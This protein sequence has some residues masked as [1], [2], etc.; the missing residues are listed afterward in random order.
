MKQFFIVNIRSVAV[1]LVVVVACGAIWYAAANAEPALGTYAVAEGNVAGALDEPGAVAAENHAGIAFQE[2]GQIAHVYVKEGDVVATGAPLADL[3]SASFK[4]SVAQANAAL[5][6]AQAKLAE[7]TTG[8]TPQTIAVSEAALS[9]AEQS[10]ANG[11]TGI[12]NTLNDAYAKANDAVRNQLAAFFSSPEQSNPQLTF[13]VSNSQVLNN[14]Q[15]LRGSASTDLNAWQAALASTTANSPGSVVDATLQNAAGSLSSI[16]SLMNE[17]LA[18]LTDETNLSAA[19]AATYK[20][21]AT[22]GL[23]EVNAAVTEVSN[24]EQAIA[25]EKSAVAQAQAGLNLTT[26]SST[27][28]EIQEQE[29][30]VA[31]AE[32]S[33]SA[34]QIAL[35]R[36]SLSAPFPGTVQDLTAQVGQVVAPGTPVLSLLNN[37]GLKIEAYVSESD[38]AKIAAGDAATVTLDAFGLGTT[39][40]ATV[41]TIDSTETQ[42]NGT[43]SYLV[44]LHF[45]KVEPQVKD[46][47]TGNVHITLAEDNDVVAIPS[48]LVLDDGNQYFVLVKTVSGVTR[49]QVQVGLVGDDGMTEITSGVSASDT[50]ADF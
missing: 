40:P 45:T 34:A 33:V 42:V 23:N 25:S 31:Q 4:A 6:A 36:T 8:A 37:A 50:L 5:A 41:S 2:A 13:S 19:T 49:K 47:M 1:I 12:P 16:Q 30:A 28:Q 21:S 20:V 17:S 15:N 46:G 7:L 39:F 27:T 11:Y 43:P 29:A 3:D 48:R 26:A 38:V 9:S 22:T 35:N 24:A 14:I 10:L 18:A 32:A 44:T